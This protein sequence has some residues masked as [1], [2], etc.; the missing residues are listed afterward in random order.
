MPGLPL[1]HRECGARV[2]SLPEVQRRKR[3]RLHSLLYEVMTPENTTRLMLANLIKTCSFQHI[4]IEKEIRPEQNRPMQLL[5]KELDYDESS[6]EN[7]LVD[8]ELSDAISEYE[9]LCDDD[10]E[11]PFPKNLCLCL[12]NGGVRFLITPHIK[13]NYF[14]GYGAFRTVYHYYKMH[15]EEE[16][17]SFCRL[18]IR[19][20][21]CLYEM[22]A[23]NLLKHSNRPP[24]PPEL[25]LTSVI[26]FVNKIN[27]MNYRAANDRRLFKNVDRSK[28]TRRDTLVAD[29]TDRG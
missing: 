1:I 22:V 10:E 2:L 8:H 29:S 18:T 12:S 13:F 25:R 28:K 15:D 5:Y 14:H 16:F 11:F 9:S 24:L 21:N 19:Q 17:Y 23:P 4:H 3:E 7:F 6:D 27:C 26:K 20:F